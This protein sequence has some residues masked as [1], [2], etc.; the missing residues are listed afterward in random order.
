MHFYRVIES[1]DRNLKT[2]RAFNNIG[3]LIDRFVSGEDLPG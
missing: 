1:L 3:V 2:A